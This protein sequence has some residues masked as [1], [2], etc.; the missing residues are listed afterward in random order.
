MNNLLR[1]KARGKRW[2]WGF[3]ASAV[4]PLLTFLLLLYIY[5]PMMLFHKP[6]GRDVT[7]HK[8]MR[9]QAAGI[10]RSLD[11]DGYIIGTSMFENTSANKAADLLGVNFANI[12]MSGS[13]IYERSFPLAL[14]LSEGADRI[15]YSLDDHYT[16]QR[17]GRDRF[18]IENFDYLYSDRYARGKLY[19]QI[20]F[21]KCAM[22]MSEDTECVGRN[23][24]ADRPNEWITNKAHYVRFGG[25]DNWFAANN[26]TQIIDA[27]KEI[28]TAANSIKKGEYI[29]LEQAELDR[30]IEKTIFYVEEYLV[31]YAEAYP[32]VKFD[33][34][35][36]PYSRIKFAQWHQ[37]YGTEARVHEA[38]VR[39]FAQAASELE[40]VNVYGFEDHD[41][42]DD[43][44]NYKDTKHYNQWVNDMM[45]ESIKSGNNM[46]SL[47]NV[48][49]YLNQARI[50]ALKF[51]II[52]L[53]ERVDKYIN[54][55]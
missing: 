20:K 17:M 49:E 34:V 46:I 10:I 39:R 47:G 2:V 28:T 3:F 52:N 30:E 25:L 32:D 37:L 9:L 22:L 6:W 48:D 42:L 33:F 7:L 53:G 31:H 50:N 1:V 38:V 8:N 11:Y 16:T 18:A 41:F 5:D 51:D 19:F 36:P 54:G 24:D 4:S 27:L 26:N 40:N 43:I 29:I 35:F 15:I 44:A 12:S 14:A 45:L 55:L 23:V 13:D 21:I